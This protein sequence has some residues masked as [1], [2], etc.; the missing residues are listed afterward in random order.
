[1]ADIPAGQALQRALLTVGSL[2]STGFPVG[3]RLGIFPSPDANF[4]ITSIFG[5]TVNANDMINYYTGAG[6]GSLVDEFIVVSSTA[7]EAVFDITSLVQSWLD[8]PSDPRRGEFIILTGNRPGTFVTSWLAEGPQIVLFTSSAPEPS[9]F[10]LVA[11]ALVGLCC[12]RRRKRR[13]NC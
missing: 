12:V 9:T 6:A 7:T 3:T 8:N 5:G 11:C 1:M 13:M 2:D 4:G 10:V